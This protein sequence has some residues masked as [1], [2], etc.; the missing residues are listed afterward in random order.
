MTVHD[1]SVFAIK[2]IGQY[3]TLPLLSKNKLPQLLIL[4]ADSPPAPPPLPVFT[5]RRSNTDWTKM[6]ISCR[7]TIQ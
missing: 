3:C 2:P 4:F 5:S 7:R 1:C 6:T